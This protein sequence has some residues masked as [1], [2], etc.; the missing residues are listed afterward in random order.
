MIV[1]VKHKP[2]IIEEVVLLLTLEEAVALKYLA[3][4]Q[5]TTTSAG[6]ARR[7][8]GPLWS[9]LDAQGVEV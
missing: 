2:I 7:L 4:N 8:Q 3:N 6:E 5:S 9:A 1:K